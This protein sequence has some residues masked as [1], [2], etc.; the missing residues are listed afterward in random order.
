MRNDGVQ[1]IGC[2]GG[3][4]GG[5]KAQ[6]LDWVGQEA[7]AGMGQRG[8]CFGD[9][10]ILSV[11][12]VEAL[13]ALRG[14]DDRA[15]V[16]RGLDQFQAG[17]TAF[18]QGAANNAGLGIEGGEVG[19]VAVELDRGGGGGAGG[20]GFAAGAGEDE[21]GFGCL[22]GNQR[23][24]PG[25]EAV[26][27]GGIGG[28]AVS[29]KQHDGWAGAEAGGVLWKGDGVGDG[30]DRAREAQSAKVGSVLAAADG[31]AGGAAGGT[32]FF[33]QNG[34]PLGPGERGAEG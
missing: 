25:D 19:D 23:P 12:E 2:G 9:Q 3:A 20:Q 6:A 1:I 17:A 24:D 32:A 7:H 30:D 33:V 29:A 26:G 18:G 8:V 14:A 16:G 15:G 4:S 27:G 28:V 10:D 31:C 22:R 5:A 21:A 11:C 13:G 34:G